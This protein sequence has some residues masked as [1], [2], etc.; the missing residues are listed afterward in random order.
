MANRFENPAAPP[1]AQSPAPQPHQPRHTPTPEQIQ[2]VIQEQ[3]RKMAQDADE[4]RR[5]AEALAL[6]DGQ[7]IAD[8]PSR[9]VVQPPTTTAPTAA[10]QELEQQPRPTASRAQPQTQR[11]V[12]MQN[13]SKFSQAQPATKPVVMWHPL[14]NNGATV[15]L[16]D[17]IIKNIPE[18]ETDP[19]AKVVQALLSEI[20]SV[21]EMVEELLAGGAGQSRTPPE[22][23]NRLYRLEAILAEQNMGMQAKAVAAKER[24]LEL[25]SKGLPAEEI[26]RL[27]S[28]GNG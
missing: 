11:Q 17:Y 10:Q 18:A 26:V 9:I 12:Q 2:R 21:R 13:Q 14:R 24:I 25:Q 5:R 16:E 1:A 19:P 28:E 8:A 6:A 22:L 15:E 4:T 23:E 20:M 7:S 27:L 3:A